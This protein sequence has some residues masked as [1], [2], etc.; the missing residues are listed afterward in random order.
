MN[1]V[2]N[3]KG[4]SRDTNN[5]D[6][7]NKDDGGAKMEINSWQLLNQSGISP[8]LLRKLSDCS[9]LCLSV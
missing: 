1:R 3:N 7:S 9:I 5:N 2:R 6:N 8:L 4:D